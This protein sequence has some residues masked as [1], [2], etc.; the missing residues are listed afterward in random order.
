MNGRVPGW[1]GRREGGAE[2]WGESGGGVGGPHRRDDAVR[3]ANSR[4]IRT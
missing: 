3:D 1:E 4:W 2:W